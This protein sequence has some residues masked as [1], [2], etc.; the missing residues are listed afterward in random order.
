M[1]LNKNSRRFFLGCALLVAWGVALPSH[2][3]TTIRFYAIVAAGG[4]VDAMA[5]IVGE[6]FGP[7]VDATVIVENKPGGGGN[8]ATQTVARSAPDG[9]SILVSG[10]NHTSNLSL[11]KDSGYQLDDLIP[12]AEL[13]RGPAVVVV[14]NRSPYQGFDQLIADAKK[15]PGEISFGTAGIGTA[16]HFA[17]EYTFF[18][19]QV[20][21]ISV[22]Y[23]G[24]GPSLTDL[25][26]EQ[27]PVAVSSLVAAMPLIKAGKLRALAVTSLKRWPGAETIPA[28]AEF[29]MPDFE[30]LSWI[31]LFAP[32]G[33][34]PAIIEQY[35][36][37]AQKVLA[38][39]EVQQRVAGLGGV[40]GEYGAAEFKKFIDRDYETVQKIV[41][42]AGMKPD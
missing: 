35:S 11:Y 31:G 30:Q 8:L 5:R 33:T 6:K 7:L 17:A 39:Q 41:K 14:P 3:A 10:N 18:T 26:G 21:M 22:P 13:M 27:I 15:R 20:K 1:S 37:A 34:P 19:A 36:Q 4:S 42:S 2:S 38:D 25:M 29:G 32:K 40:V 12:I 23:R 9:L 24:S 28:V 16:S